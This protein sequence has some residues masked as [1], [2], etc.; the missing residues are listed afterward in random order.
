MLRIIEFYPW[1]GG[2]SCWLYLGFFLYHSLIAVW[3]YTGS[4][5]ESFYKAS[6][7]LIHGTSPYKIIYESGNSGKYGDNEIVPWGNYIYPTI[8]AVQ[9]IPFLILPLFWSKKV[10]VITNFIVFILIVFIFYKKHISRIKYSYIFLIYISICILWAPV[11]DTLRIGQ[12][13]IITFVFLFLAWFAFTKNKDILGGLFLGISCTIKLTPLIIIPLFLVAA[14]RN[15]F[16]SALLGFFLTL[17]IFFPKYNWE[18]FSVIL[19]NMADYSSSMSGTSIHSM[20][21]YIVEKSG[22]GLRYLPYFVTAILY[23]TCLYIVF[24]NRKILN[25]EVILLFGMFVTPPLTAELLHHYI[26]MLLPVLWISIYVMNGNNKTILWKAIILLLLVSPLFYYLTFVKLIFGSLSGFLHLKG[27]HIISIMS[28]TAALLS[29][30]WILLPYN[31]NNTVDG[32][33]VY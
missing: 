26:T 18:Y 28:Y 7:S 1:H 30:K 9:L 21:I 33:T 12:S 17:L 6:E 22:L 31:R 11:I 5:Y 16:I 15:T 3:H 13:N 23:I 25:N 29:F 32:E 4:D 10:F 24:R 19:P 20:V 2:F 27:H 14:R 8:F